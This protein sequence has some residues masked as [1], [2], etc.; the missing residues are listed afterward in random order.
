CIAQTQD[1]TLKQIDGVYL[2]YI[3]SSSERVNHASKQGLLELS[4]RLIKRTSLEKTKQDLK[5]VEEL[6]IECDDISLSHFILWPVSNTDQPLSERAQKKVQNHLENGGFIIFDILDIGTTLDDIPVLDQLL[7]D[8][9]LG[10]LTTM[11]QDHTALNSFYHLKNLSGSYSIETPLVQSHSVGKRR[12]PSSVII[13]NS[14]WAQAWSGVTLG[15]GTDQHEEALRAGINI[16]LYAF[17]G[18]YKHDQFQI[19]NTLKNIKKDG[20]K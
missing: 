13:G 1:Q 9:N 4:K 14:N 16:V 6:D 10:G 18:E 5:E 2:S 20:P 12:R 7:G 3:R 11:P 8:V 17:T 15:R 19:Q